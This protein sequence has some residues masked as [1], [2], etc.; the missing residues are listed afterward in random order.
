MIQCGVRGE[1]EIRQQEREEEGVKYFKYQG[2]EHHKWDCPNMEVKRRRE[3]KKE[4]MYIARPQKTQQEKRLVDSTWKKV[5]KY[6]DKQ[7]ISPEDA[8]LLDREWITEEVIATY[9]DCGGCESRGVQFYENQRQ[10]FFLERQVK[11]I[12]YN[13]CQ[14][15]WDQRNR[16]ARR[17]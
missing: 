8:L 3:K 1:V 6:Y 2:V 10:S 13:L 9:V 4:K 15:I 5:Q 11:N 7:S 12:W 16:E 17:G 14:K